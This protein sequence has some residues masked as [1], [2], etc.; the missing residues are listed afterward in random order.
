M[1]LTFETGR[2]E[3]LEVD[4]AAGNFGR[5]LLSSVSIIDKELD[6]DG[7]CLLQDGV[8]TV[9][10]LKNLEKIYVESKS[11]AGHMLCEFS[12]VTD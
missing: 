11:K 9:T 7:K 5:T 12:I 2:I 1:A 4:F 3:E 6:V 8:A 10:A